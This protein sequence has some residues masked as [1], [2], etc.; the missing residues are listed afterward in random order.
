[1]AKEAVNTNDFVSKKND[2][3][4]QE[5]MESIKTKTFDELSSDERSFL[6]KVLA[7]NAGMV[8]SG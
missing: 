3:S 6:L 7:E 8:K 1:M 5:M 4:R 2:K